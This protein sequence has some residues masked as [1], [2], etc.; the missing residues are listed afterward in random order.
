MNEK[1]INRLAQVK[2]VEILPSIQEGFLA[3]GADTARELCHTQFL[4]SAVGYDGRGTGSRIALPSARST[5]QRDAFST[6]AHLTFLGEIFKLH[7]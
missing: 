2:P 6:V 3:R 1:G 4:S 5:V 7:C